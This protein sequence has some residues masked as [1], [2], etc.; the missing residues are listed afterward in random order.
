MPRNPWSVP[1]I[2]TLPQRRSSLSMLLRCSIDGTAEVPRE[3]RDRAWREHVR[4]RRGALQ[5]VRWLNGR[6]KSR[7]AALHVFKPAFLFGL[8]LFIG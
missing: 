5:R 3:L 6:Q 4:R 7:G 2:K 1:Q 8:V